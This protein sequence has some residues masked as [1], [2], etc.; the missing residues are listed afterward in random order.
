MTIFLLIRCL[1][2]S[3]IYNIMYF[4]MIHTIMISIII[5]NH[6]HIIVFFYIFPYL[7][8]YSPL[9]NVKPAA[10]PATMVLTA[11]HDDRVVPAHSF[12]FISTLQ[13]AQKGENPVLIRIETDAGHGAGTALSKAIVQAADVYSFLF[14]S[15]KSPV[16]Y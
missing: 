2:N 16:K 15:T 12:K 8:K 3:I 9:H 14:F 6:Q 1:I 10:Y 11:D 13:A 4:I 7:Y 5:I